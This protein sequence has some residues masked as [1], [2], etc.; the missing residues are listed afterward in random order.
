MKSA[1][2]TK[3]GNCK[4][5]SILMRS[6]EISLQCA[7]VNNSFY[8]R[9][10]QGAGPAERNGSGKRDVTGRG[11]AVRGRQTD[12]ISG[13]SGGPGRFWRIICLDGRA[14]QVLA[15]NLPGWAGR[16]GFG[17]DLSGTRFL[18][19]QIGKSADRAGPDFWP[20]RSAIW[21]G[22]GTEFHNLLRN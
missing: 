11:R 5:E 2:D 14:G 16:A 4:L 10:G 17:T 6:A 9:G 8:F 3:R 15:H 22:P 20:A 12:Q 21:A 18:A 13:G 19:G 7:Q 1:D